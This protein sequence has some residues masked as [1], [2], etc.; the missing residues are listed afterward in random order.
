MRQAGAA[1]PSPAAAVPRSPYVVLSCAMS[2]DGHIDDTSPRRLVLSN[3]ADLDRV[4]AQRAASDAIL[5]G[6]NTVRRDDPR[7]LVRSPARRAERARRGLP[8]SPLKV[9][10]TGRGE[11]DPSAQFFAALEG[12]AGAVV[13]CASA[14][15]AKVRERLGG[16]AEVVDA[17]DPVRLE[18]VLGDLAGR[19]VRRLLVEG[20]SAVQAQF[21]GAGLANELHLVIAPL[22][23][24]DAAAPRF[25]GGAR[26]SG[27]NLVEAQPLGEVVLLRYLLPR[28]EDRRWLEAAVELSRRCPPSPA[29][30][31]VGA[32]IV[33]AD[34]AELARG[35]SRE[36][37]PHEHAEEAAL[38]KLPA[39][40][41]RL[42][43]ATLYSSLEPCG[44][45]RSRPM[46]C[47]ALALRAG[48]R[49]VVY[50]LREPP[51]LAAGHGAA[52]LRAAGV[53]VIEVPDLAGRVREVNAHLLPGSASTST[54]PTSASSSAVDG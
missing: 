47:A 12:A 49:R 18:R 42:A 28:A 25:G 11:L 27:L 22:L 7:L 4:D 33:G 52:A 21:L 2:L 35:F 6:A 19:G 3:E 31:S 36:G 48:I 44:A 23:V 51:L 30:Y 38:R 20:G 37:D 46:S 17:G 13:Y 26:A 8:A 54:A 39:G 24:G 32:V 5:V 43:E 1:T 50:A 29:A 41:P 10:V 14:A 9:T 53:T 34:G 40:D 16:V 15:V 45:R